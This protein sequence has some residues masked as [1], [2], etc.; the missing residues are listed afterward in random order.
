MKSLT[1][2]IPLYMSKHEMY[3]V[4][5]NVPKNNKAFDILF[6]NDDSSEKEVD[7][8]I[9]NNRNLG[10]FWSIINSLRNINSKYFLSIDPDDILFGGIDWNKL[11]ILAGEIEKLD[12]EYDLLINSHWWIDLNDEIKYIP[13]NETSHIFNACSIYN[14]KNVEQTVKEINLHFKNESLTYFEDALLL[15]LT[16]RSGKI[17]EI[18]VP[19]YKYFADRGVT[20]KPVSHLLE[21]EQ[22]RRVLSNILNNANLKILDD[23]INFRMN[24]VKSYLLIKNDVIVDHLIK[25][26]NESSKVSILVI[27]EDS[28]Q[29]DMLTRHL[30]QSESIMKNIT[31]VSYDWTFH[32]YFNSFDNYERSQKI[33]NF[34]DSFDIVISQE[35]LVNLKVDY[36]RKN[37]NKPLFIEL[38]HGTYAKRPMDFLWKGNN[39]IDFIVSPNDYTTDIYK[40]IGFNDNQI[41]KFGYPRNN[42]YH[43]INTDLVNKE[44]REELKIDASSEIVL[45][46]PTWV[47]NYNEKFNNIIFNLKTLVNDLKPNE[48]LLVWP[49]SNNITTSKNI[50]YS[51]EFLTEEEKSKIYFRSE[52]HDWYKNRKYMDGADIMSI[53]KRMITDYSSIIFDFKNI[54]GREISFYTPELDRY[55]NKNTIE[56][57]EE[58]FK[59]WGKIGNIKIDRTKD[60]NFIESFKNY[61]YYSKDADLRL[62]EFVVEQ[63]E[64]LKWKK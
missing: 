2:V 32:K 40:S 62:F 37:K 57:Y 63:I 36:R 9:N 55:Q 33:E 18:D 21:I 8:A 30:R 39:E 54:Y 1:I 15:S 31:L 7:F 50:T 11:G 26:I 41:L 47:P 43:E 20:Q 45:F 52:K 44:I 16:S 53:A 42:Y 49:H 46:A 64:E 58:E 59:D 35:Y 22:A 24:R 14:V 12:Q 5:K 6:I 17:L 38:Y 34:L 4:Y 27:W 48:V 23:R 19:F 60:F 3:D 29:L 10:K 13:S 61:D 51:T 25:E 28:K 56:C